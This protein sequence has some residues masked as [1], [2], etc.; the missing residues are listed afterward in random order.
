MLI[1]VPSLEHVPMLATCFAF[2]FLFVASYLWWFDS[3]CD[4][5][6]HLEFG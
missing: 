3:Y 6:Q 4:E 1:Y 2:V 5:A